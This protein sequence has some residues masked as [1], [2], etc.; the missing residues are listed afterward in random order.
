MA[1]RLQAVC[2]PFEWLCYPL[3]RNINPFERLCHPFVGNIN[4]FERLGDPFV[5]NIKLFKRLGDPFVRNKQ[6]PF[7]KRLRVTKHLPRILLLYHLVD[8]FLS[9]VSIIIAAFQGQQFGQYK[10]QTVD[11]GPR[12]ADW[13]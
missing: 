6:R 5:R 11:C 2:Q 1:F 10:T 3:A 13:V 8:L 12:T 9:L 7:G 4:P